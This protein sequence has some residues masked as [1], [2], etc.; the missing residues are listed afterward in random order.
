MMLLLLA[1]SGAAALAAAAMAAVERFDS[2][3]HSVDEL[4]AYTRVPVLATIPLIVTA[5]D[6]RRRRLRGALATALALAVLATAVS[7]AHH[8]ARD[9]DALVAVLARS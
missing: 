7:A 6:R 3:F 1:L 9:Q 4:C 8:V 2:S 5:A